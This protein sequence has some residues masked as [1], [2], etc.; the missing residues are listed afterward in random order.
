VR[1]R[2]QPSPV[3]L[4]LRGAGPD[5]LDG[6][7]F[8]HRWPDAERGAVAVLSGRP[9]ARGTLAGRGR[10]LSTHRRGV[11]RQSGSQLTTGA[12]I[13]RGD[14]RRRG[15]TALVQLLARVFHG[16]R[17]TVGLSRR[18]R[19]A[20]L[21]LPVPQDHAASVNQTLSSAAARG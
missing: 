2:F 8:L 18:Y 20:G 3:R 16:L 5:R 14:L 1:P 6:A 11:A 13:A 4:P 15:G 17:R 12:P 10:A 21:A 19:M 7:L 9:Q